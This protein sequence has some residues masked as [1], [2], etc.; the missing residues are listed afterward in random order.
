MGVTQNRTS[1]PTLRKN[2]LRGLAM[3]ILVSFP[4][5]KKLDKLVNGERQFDVFQP[6]IIKI[7]ATTVR[8]DLI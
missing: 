6:M 7:G 8:L 2:N 3:N 1:M 5:V 4:N